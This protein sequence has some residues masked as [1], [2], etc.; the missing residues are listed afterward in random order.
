MRFT[1]AP[2]KFDKSG[3][4]SLYGGGVHGSVLELVPFTQVAPSLIRL[5]WAMRGW[6]SFSSVTIS[7]RDLDDDECEVEVSQTDIPQRDGVGGRIDPGDVERGW[8]H[9]IFKPI[10]DILGYPLVK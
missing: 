4:F 7:L 10:A 5:R 9:M 6:P 3:E 1:R 2:A 8:E